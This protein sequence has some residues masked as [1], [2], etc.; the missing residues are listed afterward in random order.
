M[1]SPPLRFIPNVKSILNSLTEVADKSMKQCAKKA[2][3]E[4]NDNMNIAA[5]YDGRPTWQQRGHVS[6]NGM[7]TSTSFDTGKILDIE[8]LIKYCQD[9]TK[10]KTSEEKSKH[11]GCVKNYDGSSGGMESAGVVKL[12]QRSE[13]ERQVR[14]AF[15][16][17]GWGL[18][19]V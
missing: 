11:I 19:S 5:G 4:N 15:Y 16:F 1:P 2:I 7:V 10:L 14:Y 9:C 6:I 13:L 18:K 12:I 8:C 17:G 3:I